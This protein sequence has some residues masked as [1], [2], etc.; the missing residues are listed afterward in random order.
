MKKKIVMG[1][2]ESRIYTVGK[3]VKKNSFR[4]HVPY[5][6]IFF[7]KHFKNAQNFF[8]PVLSPPSLSTGSNEVRVPIKNDNTME[9]DQSFGVMSRVFYALPNKVKAMKNRGLDQMVVTTISCRV[10][11]NIR[12]FF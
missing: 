6:S 9:L 10:T 12:R 2:Q 7:R 3:G 11:I 8:P 1:F 5:K 4:G